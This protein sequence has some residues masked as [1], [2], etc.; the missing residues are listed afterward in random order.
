MDGNAQPEQNMMHFGPNSSVVW[1]NMSEG[2]S[3]LLDRL[4]E[5]MEKLLIILRDVYDRFL[6]VGPMQSNDAAIA[7][8]RLTAKG[9]ACTQHAEYIDG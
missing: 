6:P 2:R 8:P 9:P 5:L 3:T 4:A 7:C 1:K